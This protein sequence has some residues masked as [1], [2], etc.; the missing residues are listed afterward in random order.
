MKPG[1][2]LAELEEIDR[3]RTARRSFF[4]TARRVESELLREQWW[5]L[6]K[7]L[8]RA[9]AEE[10]RRRKLAADDQG[11]DRYLEGAF[12]EIAQ[13]LQSL[14]RRD[15]ASRKARAALTEEAA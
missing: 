14:L 4:Q 12:A 13:D 7:K 5:P 9:A 15:V 1:Y 6:Y 10:C 8:R 2:Y 3:A 11:V